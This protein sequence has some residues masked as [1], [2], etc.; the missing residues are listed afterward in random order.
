MNV[1]RFIHIPN[2]V[3]IT[4]GMLI[5]SS[6]SLGDSLTEGTPNIGETEKAPTY[7]PVGPSGYKVL[8]PEIKMNQI[9]GVG[10][11]RQPE[12][13]ESGKIAPVPEERPHKEI[14]EPALDV[15]DTGSEE[16]Q[17]DSEPRLPFDHTFRKQ[18]SSESKDDFRDDLKK[19]MDRETPVLVGPPMAPMNLT[20]ALPEPKKEIF[21]RRHSTTAPKIK[22]LQFTKTKTQASSVERL[23]DQEPLAPDEWVSFQARQDPLELSPV[24]QKTETLVK[25]PDPDVSD[26]I[27]TSTKETVQNER[28]DQKQPGADLPIAELEKETISAEDPKTVA[29]KPDESR[30]EVSV[31]AKERIL[32]PLDEEALND[33]GLRL[34]LSQTTPVLEELSLL[35]TRSPDLNLTDYDPS[36]INTVTAPE[37]LAL[38]LES[39]KRELRILD[40]KIF[41]IIPPSKYAQFHD[42]IRQSVSHTYLACEAISNYFQQSKLED[43]HKVNEHILK[44]RELIR[45]TRKQHGS[46]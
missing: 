4:C 6:P 42:L 2:L 12:K 44:A 19:K 18:R 3:L 27:E 14:K 24:E 26:K 29:E 16:I 10:Q 15:T 41:S 37:D 39:M 40:S 1:F 28:E 30:V 17:E 13:S 20:E 34:Y 5:W 22:E 43:L 35:M 25:T 33:T 8:I 21:P 23:E 9:I 7:A 32:S 45:M 11:P 36:E 31:A 38:R 46:I